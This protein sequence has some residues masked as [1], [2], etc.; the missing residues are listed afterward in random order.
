MRSDR[1]ERIRRRAYEIWQSEGHA[2]GRHE[3]HWHRAER[4]IAADEAGSRVKN[5]PRRQPGD[6]RR[7]KASRCEGGAKPQC[8]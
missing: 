2:H 4:E 5:S 8:R 6:K 7:E 3:D 1:E